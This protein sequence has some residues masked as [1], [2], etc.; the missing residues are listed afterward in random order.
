M[1]HW[2]VPLGL[3]VGELRGS[4]VDGEHVYDHHSYLGEFENETVGPD[5]ITDHCVAPGLGPCRYH[6]DC[7]GGWGWRLLSAIPGY[8]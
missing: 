7:R 1:E 5:A 2:S 4:L 8:F 6:T 3:E